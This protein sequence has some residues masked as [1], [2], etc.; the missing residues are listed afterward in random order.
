MYFITLLVLDSSFR[1]LREITIVVGS[2]KRE[3]HSLM[4]SRWYGNELTRP[5][6][7]RTRT[8]TTHPHI[9]LLITI[10]T[11]THLLTNLSIE[12]INSN[13]QPRCAPEHDPT[14]YSIASTPTAYRRKFTD[15]SLLIPILEVY[16]VKLHFSLACSKMALVYAWLRLRL[17]RLHKWMDGCVDGLFCNTVEPRQ[18]RRRERV[19]VSEVLCV[20]C[21][22]LC[23][24]C[25][26]RRRSV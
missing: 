26:S 18:C 5:S 4:V 20:C 19:V 3:I 2:I 24:V 10:R 23:C 17:S 16:D 11:E 7:T 1:D 22:V 25:F 12:A 9:A 13:I 14:R 8:S 6:T 15:L 21:A